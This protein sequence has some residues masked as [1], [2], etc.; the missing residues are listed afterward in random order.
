MVSTFADI[1]YSSLSVIFKSLIAVEAER[2]LTVRVIFGIVGFTTIQ[3]LSTPNTIGITFVHYIA[4]S[5][6]R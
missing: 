2:F 1:F 4:S 5:L 6:V 3:G